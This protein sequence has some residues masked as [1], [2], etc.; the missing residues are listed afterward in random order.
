MYAIVHQNQVILTQGNWN[1]IMFNN[2]LAEECGVTKRVYVADEANVPLIFNDD[3][4]ILKYFD[5]KPNYNGRTEW[6]DGPVYE[7]TEN[8]V[9]GSYIVKELDL[10][11]AKGNL[12]NQLPSLRYGKEIQTIKIVVQDQ[13]VNIK[14]DRETRSILSSN[15]ITCGDGYVNWK[16]DN[17]WLQLTKDDLTLILQ[18]INNATQESYDW[19]FSKMLEID[20]CQTLEQID[21]VVIHQQITTLH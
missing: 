21:K 6:I 15:I 17:L 8:H 14:T 10:N 20:N 13:F 7:I 9:V 3:T 11:I 1:P 2:V 16:F 19:E 18:Q 12:K 5:L 4:K